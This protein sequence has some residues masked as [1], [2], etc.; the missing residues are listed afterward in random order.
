MTS[1][2]PANPGRRSLLTGGALMVPTLALVGCS[3]NDDD[4]A[5]A[6]ARTSSAGAPGVASSRVVRLTVAADT[7]EDVTDAF[8][9]AMEQLETDHATTIM[10]DRG[11]YLVRGITVPPDRTV[12][13]RGMGIGYVGGSFG[14]RI[15]RYD[16]GTEPLLLAQGDTDTL[17][18]AEFNTPPFRTRLELYDLELHGNETAGDGLRVFRGQQCNFERIRVSRCSGTAVHLTQMFNSAMTKVFTGYSGNGSD[19]PAMLIDGTDEGSTAGTNTLHI[20]DCEWETNAGT[21]LVIDGYRGAPSVGILVSGVKMERI[22]GDF[23]LIRV[24]RHGK[25]QLTNSYLYLGSDT[26]HH[27]LQTAGSTMLS[28]VHLAHGGSPDFQVVQEDGLLLMAAVQSEARL[29]E[30]MLRVDAEVSD[31]GCVL[32]GL[33]ALDNNRLVRDERDRSVKLGKRVVPV[34]VVHSTASTKLVTGGV[35]AGWALGAESADALVVG[36]AVL[37]GGLPD[38]A[39]CELALRWVVSSSGEG[40]VTFKATVGAAGTDG[41]LSA[42]QVPVSARASAPSGVGDLVESILAPSITVNDGNLVQVQVARDIDDSADTF[43]GEVLLLTA[44]LLV[45]TVP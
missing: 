43:T 20:T 9:E 8:A 3:A 31:Q 15:R 14:T 17:E 30:A 1:E 27:Q 12:I 39:V 28:N 22:E 5:D 6:G 4:Q 16:D 19:Q 10:L 7:E 23:P 38:D 45:S 37:P 34:Q 26:Q 33:S 40:G 36:Q 18:P 32:R 35:A 44:H 2:H 21:D 24:S 13:I 42:R 29:G 11:E 41:S 25:L